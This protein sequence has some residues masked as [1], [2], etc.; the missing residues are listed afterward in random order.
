MAII[1]DVFVGGPKSL[2][3]ERGEWVSSIAR[4]QVDGSI[5]LSKEGFE[6]DKVTQEYHGGPDAAVC[7]HL[8]DHYEFWRDRYGVRL[9]HGHLGENLVLRELNEADVCAGDVVRIG[10]AV[11]QVSGPRIPCETQARRAGRRDWVKLTIRENRTGFYLRVLEPGIVAAGDLWLLQERFHS[12]GSIPAI[13]Q[14]LYLDFNVDLATEFS[15]MDGLAEWWRDQFRERLGRTSRHWSQDILR[16][17]EPAS[18]A[19]SDGK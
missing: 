4:K 2:R 5:A 6:G 8:V 3:D 19:E 11:A 12:S 16:P 14:C 13:N 1:E 10:S 18:A 17:D 9:D 15:Q 7:V